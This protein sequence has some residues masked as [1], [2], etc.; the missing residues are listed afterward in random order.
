M[1]RYFRSISSNYSLNDNNELL[2]K[3]H[4]NNEFKNEIDKS[5]NKDIKNNNN[6]ILMKIPFVKNIYDYLLNIHKNSCHCS[7]DKFRKEMINN[8]IYYKGIINDY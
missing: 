4:Y 3:Y 6:Y 5:Y 2:Y 1:K 8:R 7:F